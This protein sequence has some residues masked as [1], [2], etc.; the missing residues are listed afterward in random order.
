MG[1]R[2]SQAQL[3]AR[4]HMVASLVAHCLSPRE[5]RL[6]VNDNTDWGGAVSDRT[7]RRYQRLAREQLRAASRLDFASEAGAFGAR[8][9][10][11]IKQA[12]LH[13]D[14]KT[15]LA[16]NRQKGELLRIYA[17]HTGTLEAP[18]D[19]TV[20]E[21]ARAFIARRLAGLA[22]PQPAPADPGGFERPPDSGLA[23]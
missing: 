15:M 7:L 11:L 9:D 14:S 17:D 2:A 20:A 6:V 1:R 16:A 4:V 10:Q 5:I 22:E 18:D 3:E 21:E 12:F 8:L 23:P 19:H 13:K